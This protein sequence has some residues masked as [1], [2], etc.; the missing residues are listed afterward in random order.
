MSEEFVDCRR[1]DDHTITLPIAKLALPYHP[2]WEPI[3]ADDPTGEDGSEN[4]EQPPAPTTGKAAR[5]SA[6]NTTKE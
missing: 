4:A 2:D 5:T 1:K 3:P 6:K